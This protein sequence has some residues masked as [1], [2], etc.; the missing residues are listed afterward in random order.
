[1]ESCDLPTVL[2]WEALTP[3]SVICDHSAKT[4]IQMSLNVLPEKLWGHRANRE[5]LL[6][7]EDLTALALVVE[8]RC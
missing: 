5:K 3:N 4:F 1:M 7:I 2:G 8:I 6:H